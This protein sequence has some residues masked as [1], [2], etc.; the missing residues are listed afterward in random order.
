M[1]RIELLVDDMDGTTER[2]RPVETHS[3][4]IDDD[5]Y[6]IDLHSDNAVEMREYFARYIEHGRPVRKMMSVNHP[7]GKK[8]TV[9]R[10]K[11][12]HIDKAQYDA[13]R[14]WLRSQG[15]TVSN[16]GKIRSDLHA[17]YEAAHPPTK[18]SRAP[19]TK[20]LFSEAS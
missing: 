14:A 19:F 16:F 18:P 17:L 7:A 13:E 2:S 6:E 12:P 5:R 10:A 4:A 8:R 15:H 11:S 9:V 20:G 3:F 1:A